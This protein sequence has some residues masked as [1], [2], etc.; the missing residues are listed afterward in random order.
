MAG[1]GR[2]RPRPA[3]L[4]GDR[5]LSRF[6]PRRIFTI[7]PRARSF[8]LQRPPVEGIPGVLGQ[9]ETA[10]IRIPLATSPT[11]RHSKHRITT[12]TW[13]AGDHVLWHLPLPETRTGFPHPV[14]TSNQGGPRQEFPRLQHRLRPD[15]HHTATNPDRHDPRRVR[16]RH[17]W[18]LSIR[19]GP[20]PGSGFPS[21]GGSDGHVHP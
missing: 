14:M 9:L 5:L 6:E 10:G 16:R 7:S 18:L 3:G 4:S 20:D 1:A 19:R 21:R 12:W 15:V 8:L 13:C 2:F 17:G 11:R